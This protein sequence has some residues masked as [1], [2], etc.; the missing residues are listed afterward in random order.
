MNLFFNKQHCQI[1]VTNDMETN[2]NVE[3]V[4][5]TKETIIN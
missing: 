5:L 2:F 1:F 4:I 3:K